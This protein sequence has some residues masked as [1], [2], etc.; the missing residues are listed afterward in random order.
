MDRTGIIIYYVT[1]DGETWAK[2]VG[3]KLHSAPY[4]I[5]VK[6]VEFTES[7]VLPQNSNKLCIF[8]ITPDLLDIKDLNCLGTFRLES[9]MGVLTGVNFNDIELVAKRKH[10][11]NVLDW[12]FYEMVEHDLET[13]VRELMMSII[14]AY[15]G[16]LDLA[17]NTI[18]SPVSPKQ[19]PDYSDDY[20]RLPPPKQVNSVQDIF[21][22]VKYRFSGF[23]L[24]L[25]PF[26]WYCLSKPV[27]VI[28]LFSNIITLFLTEGHFIVN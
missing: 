17:S 12:F 15:E 23:N 25:Y 13:S 9:C 5:D 21:V 24:S 22:K 2:F 16:D 26:I 19:S 11:R 27:I 20:D 6:L 18:V 3:N 10:C 1:S 8:F 7:T 4:S 28:L 14:G